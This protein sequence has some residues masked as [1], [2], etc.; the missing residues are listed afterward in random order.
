M[1]IQNY[2]Q[3][4]G[5][6]SETA[7]LKNV[8]AHAG[9]SAPHTKKPY[10]EAMLLGIG[11][12]VGAGYF[13][14]EM[15]DGKWLVLGARHQWQHTGA[16]FLQTI[17]KR[18]GATATVKES[19]GVKAAAANLKEALKAGRPAITWGSLAGMPY[20]G[21]PIELLKMYVHVFVVYGWDEKNNRVCLDDR[22]ATPLHLTPSQLAVSRAAITSLKNRILTI[23]APAKPA[24]L[25]QA[26][27]A[28]I[29]DC[30]D[31]MLD[32]KIKNF[33]LPSLEKWADL[34]TD[35]KDKK[36]WP[37]VFKP[38]LHLYR[39]LLG[40]YH[41]IE[42]GG[43]GGSAFRTMYADF[44]DEAATVLDKKSQP[45]LRDAALQ[46]R[47]S[48]KLWSALA[49]AALPEDVKLLGEAR[50]VTAVKYQLFAA[51]GASAESQMPKINRRL[52]AIEA[53]AAK[54][55]PLN[56]KQTRELFDD[57][58]NHVRKVYE[59]EDKAISLLQKIV[60]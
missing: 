24:D 5:A 2:K 55:F 57:L 32:P 4:G 23:K 41:Q 7:A 44:L 30:C 37:Q 31:E 15:C 56:A 43:T 48:A 33:G 39:A 29:R 18:I 52:A 14:F 53:E 36:G 12:G 50:E 46:Y 26:I 49:K 22:A 6:H 3:F 35:T 1:I 16:G 19:G 11:G 34:I 13:M 45:V 60:A 21:L 51:R 38:G 27:H 58:H 25:K 47:K 42:N 59:A 54:D 40:T 8:L 20:Y 9:V 17:S 28:G 10:T